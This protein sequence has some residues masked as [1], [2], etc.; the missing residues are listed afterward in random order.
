LWKYHRT[1]HLTKHPNPL[2]TLYADT[3]QE[4]FDILGV[5]PVE[6]EVKDDPVQPYFEGQPG[7]VHS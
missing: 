2:L 5:V 1:H 3:E 4:F 7:E 6:P